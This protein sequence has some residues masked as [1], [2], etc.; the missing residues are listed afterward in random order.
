MEEDQRDYELISMK[1]INP[2]L[3]KL[4]KTFLTLYY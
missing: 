3:E 1:G 4:L 2:F